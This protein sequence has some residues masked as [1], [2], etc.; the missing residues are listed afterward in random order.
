[1]KTKM[2][3]TGSAEIVS[4]LRVPFGIAV[5]YEKSTLFW[6]DRSAFKV[7]YSGL[8]GGTA[9]TIVEEYLMYPHGIVVDQTR[10]YI[11][12]WVVPAELRSY[13]KTG[14]DM[15]SLY[16]GGERIEQMALITS[17][18]PKTTRRNHCAGQQRC[19]DDSIC[20]LTD[21]CFRCLSFSSPSD[22]RFKPE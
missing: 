13:N 3:G 11:G 16:T 10:L 7:Q 6:V 14:G 17:R 2:D 4:G 1:M 21:A 19:S 18:P 22:S 12:T 5:D 20:V 8:D 9:T 15:K